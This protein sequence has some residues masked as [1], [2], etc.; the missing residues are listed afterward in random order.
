MIKTIQNGINKYKLIMEGWKMKLDILYM[1]KLLN[2]SYIWCEYIKPY[3]QKSNKVFTTIY[4][5]WHHHRCHP[6]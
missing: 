5:G 4:I 6:I 2:I 3:F 1:S